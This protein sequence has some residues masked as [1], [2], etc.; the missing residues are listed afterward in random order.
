MCGI[1]GFVNFKKNLIDKKSIIEDMTNTLIKRG[2]NEKGYY[3]SKNALLGHRRLIVVDPKGGSQPMIK[4]HNGKKYIIVYNGELYN[5]EDIRKELL[6]AGYE[7][8]SY[9]DTEVLLTSYI[10]W[11]EDCV[12]H[13]NGIFA[14]AIYSET[15]KK[16]FLA[17]DPLGVKPLFYTIKNNNLIF[18]SEIKTLL[19]N[20]LVEPILTKEGL[21]EIFALGPARNL[22][23]GV[24]K[25]IHEIPPANFIEFTEHKFKLHE[26]WRL[27]CKPHTENAS[28]TAEHIKFLLTDAIKRQLYAD[29]PV[30]TFLSG[31]L[32]SSIISAVAASEFKKHGKTLNTYS[33]DYKDNNLYFKNDNFVITPDSVWAEKMRKFIGSNHHKIIN[34]NLDLASALYDAVKAND[35][36]GMADIDSSLFLF[37]KGV[38]E[39]NVVSLSGERAI[40]MITN[41]VKQFIN[42]GEL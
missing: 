20:P 19:A 21:T 39:K 29:V 9:S 35:I 23:S 12:N 28:E 24:L 1:A 37:C 5:T 38:A 32:D 18:G 10:H 6:E 13:I 33:I 22:G 2:P 15:D 4:I 25:D 42:I 7:F 8:S 31:G 26:Y 34:N 27:S 11:K 16:I 41:L 40:Q 30:C 14:F 3:I 17:R 36:P